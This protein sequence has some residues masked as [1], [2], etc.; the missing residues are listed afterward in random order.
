MFFM[1]SLNVCHS[2]TVSVH[3]HPASMRAVEPDSTASA[4]RGDGVEVVNS[5]LGKVS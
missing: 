3:T 4:V 2:Q 1:L 5:E